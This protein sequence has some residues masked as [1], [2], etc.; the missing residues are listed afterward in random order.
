MQYSDT[1]YHVLRF[2]QYIIP[3]TS[4][5]T[6]TSLAIDM[7][8]RFFCVFEKLGDKYALILMNYL[9][10]CLEYLRSAECKLSP[11]GV[12]SGGT[13]AYFLT[14]ESIHK[15]IGSTQHWSV[16]WSS[17]V[18]FLCMQTSLVMS[19]VYFR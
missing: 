19:A 5:E 6:N 11:L 13:H 8:I 16:G 12:L 1:V 7:I 15:A 18:H 9:G 4:Q 17:G 10:V 14:C 3:T 2:Q